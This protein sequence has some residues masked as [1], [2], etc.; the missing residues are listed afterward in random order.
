[1]AWIS[2]HPVHNTFASLCVKNGDTFKVNNDCLAILEEILRKLDNEDC[3]LRTF[4]R[5]I[6]FG[7]NIRKNL[8][9]LLLH[10]KDDA[11]IT[12][13]TKIIDTTIK[14]LVNLTIPVECLLSIDSMSRSDVGKHTIFEL[15]KLLTTSKAAF[16]DSKSTKAVVDHMKYLVENYSQLDLEQ[17]DSINNC[18]LLLRNI[19][20]VPEA[21]TTVSNSS[22]QNQIIW[23]LFT[24]SIDKIIIYLMSCPQKVKHKFLRLTQRAISV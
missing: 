19:L 17:C 18:L 1:M 21:K 23:N 4:R 12:D 15:N 10:V 11:K 24:Q 6:G 8:I 2:S 13:A 14:I 5:A 22:M 7:Q 16:I 3:S 9:P 20:H